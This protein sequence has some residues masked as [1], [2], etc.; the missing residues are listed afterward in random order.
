MGFSETTLQLALQV[1]VTE[2]LAGNVVNLSDKTVKHSTLN[3]SK[4]L[5]AGT[6]PPVTKVASF[7]M[8]LDPT[9]HTLDLTSIPGTNGATVDGTGLKVQAIAFV[10]T[11]TNANKIAV[12][13]GGANPYN[14]LG[15]TFTFELLAGQELVLYGNDATPDIAAGAKNI[16]FTGTGVQT[17][18][19][20]VVMG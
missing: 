2:I 12:T 15:T 10:A 19:I 14:L 11:A 5:D 9:T 18:S 16:L 17:M 6:T 3:L 4:T 20:I 13:Y 8:T 1:T 7:L